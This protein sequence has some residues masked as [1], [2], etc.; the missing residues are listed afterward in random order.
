L[1]SL[2]FIAQINYQL[3]LY[4]MFYNDEL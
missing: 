1:K 3:S 4:I 2:F